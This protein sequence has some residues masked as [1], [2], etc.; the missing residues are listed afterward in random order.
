MQVRAFAIVALTTGVVLGVT[1]QA[2]A[3]A[4]ASACLANAPQTVR[5]HIAGFARDVVRPGSNPDPTALKA[6]AALLA[7]LALGAPAPASVQKAV[8]T[9][10]TDKQIAAS[11]SAA[12]NVTAT[13]KPGAPGLLGLAIENNLVQQ[14]TTATLLTLSTSPYAF[15]AWH[16]DSADMYKNNDFFTRIALSASFDLTGNT[17][18]PL[19]NATG[20]HLREWTAKFRL[21]GDHSARSA[22]VQTRWNASMTELVVQELL[23]KIALMDAIGASVDTA[24][25]QFRADLQPRLALL[26]Q[27]T[28][29]KVAGEIS[30]G[31]EKTIVMPIQKGAIAFP[32]DVKAAI[33]QAR[34]RVLETTALRA[35]AETAFNAFVQAQDAKPEVSL[36][37]TRALP[38]DGHNHVDAK[39]LFQSKVWSPMTL[40]ANATTSWNEPASS[41]GNFTFRAI[42]AGASLECST[43]SPFVD[44][45]SDWSKLTLSLGLRLEHMPND[46]G[47]LQAQPNTGLLQL[48]VDVPFGAGI[49][50]PISF[51]ASNKQDLVTGTK[52]WHHGL[53]FGLTF[54]ADKLVALTASATK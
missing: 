54:D 40:V 12:K 33:R 34:T 42:T 38:A 2:R 7:A 45:S 26:A 13:E 22:D 51:S 35:Q 24:F 23:A 11:T 1:P 16:N 29:E 52:Q 17:S 10:R 49:T 21:T 39:L 37:V 30:C 32:S 4:G 36:A 50:L 31:L 20:S 5:D 6:D 14:S 46:Y 47:V 3:Q 25:S 41:S 18:D 48:K 44:K 19:A 28:A 53:F 43:S 27:N 15:I 8:E 9:Q